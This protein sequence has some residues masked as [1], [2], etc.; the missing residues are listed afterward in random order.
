MELDAHTFPFPDLGGE[1]IRV[2]GEGIYMGD[3]ELYAEKLG[4]ETLPAC[5]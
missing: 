5:T 3:R 4:Y 1:I 2:W